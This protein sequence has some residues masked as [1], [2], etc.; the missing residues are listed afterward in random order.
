MNRR[1]I[2]LSR[3]RLLRTVLTGFLMSASVTASSQVFIPDFPANDAEHNTN[4]LWRPRIA[5]AAD[6][7]FSIAWE[8]YSDR[9]GIHPNSTGRSQIAV[10]RFLPD[11][12]PH[13][14]LSFFQ[15]ESSTLS[16]WLFDFLEHA[17]IKYLGDGTLVLLMQHTGRL[18]IGTDDVASSEITLGAIDPE[19]QIIKLSQFG[20]NLQ[21][22]LIFTSSSRQYNPRLALTPDNVIVAALEESS[23]DSEFRNAA[24]R[25][26]DASLN[27]LITREIPHSDGVG[28]APHILADVATN[29]QLFAVVW[30]DGRF[31]DQWSVGIQFY[32]DDGILGANRRINETEPGT[33]YALRPSV[34]MNGS[35]RSVAV[36]FD[37]RNGN[38]LFG[39]IFDSAGEPAGGNFQISDTP[40]GGDIYFRPEVTIRDDGSFMVVWT[41]ST[42]VQ[43]AFRARGRQFDPH[44]IPRGDPFLIPDIDV[45]SGYP[46]VATDGAAYYCVWL[47]DRL[48]MNHVNAYAKKV[49]A[50][51]TYA[52]NERST[53]PDSF[54][55]HPPYPN[56]FNPETTVT[57][58]IP[59]E[60]R[61]RLSVHDLLGRN[62]MDLT[63]SYYQAG[64]HSVLFSGSRLSSGI[65]V[66]RLEFGPFAETRSVFLIK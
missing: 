10:R 59:E 47:D 36:W 48:G 44:G 12:S 61:V 39:Q 11:G 65:Y 9:P 51:I 23:Y 16:L 57:F 18:S 40:A 52:A 1:T 15:G 2:I 64:L 43:H 22:P 31:S 32:T 62:V 58:E 20:S 66:L 56:P 34:A 24:F 8:D 38:Q 29:G 55:L 14:P 35:G 50:V 7:N 5:A 49:D 54:V 4:G 60:G 46:H 6:G 27:E 45:Y 17:E 33:A 42:S 25:A 63:D 30:Q 37:S 21:Y 26:L 19:G 3:S 13:G 41:D 28:E 53:M